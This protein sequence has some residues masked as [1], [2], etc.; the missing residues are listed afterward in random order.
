MTTLDS[1]A[2]HKWAHLLTPAPQA[3]HRP[4]GRILRIMVGRAGEGGGWNRGPGGLSFLHLRL[5]LG[6]GGRV[7]FFLCTAAASRAN[8]VMERW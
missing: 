3:N 1:M 6:G 5:A 2:H 4:T 8:Q 7:Y